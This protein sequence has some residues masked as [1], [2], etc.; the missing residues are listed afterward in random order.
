MADV[1]FQGSVLPGNSIVYNLHKL[2]E[3]CWG[4]VLIYLLWIK[5][6]QPLGLLE[7]SV[8]AWNFVH[9]L[10]LSYINWGGGGNVFI[11]N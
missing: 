10:N 2:L 3:A 1:V 6:E 8:L 7:A 11:T 4:G 5:L 9:K